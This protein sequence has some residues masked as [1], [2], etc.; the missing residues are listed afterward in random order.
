MRRPVV[1]ANWKMNK[2]I[3]EAIEFANGL[4]RAFY[5]QDTIDIVICPSFVTLSEVKDIILDSNIFLGAQD[6]HFEDKGA[7][8]GEVSGLQLKD[9]GC[10]FVIIGH[11]E[12]RQYFSETDEMINRKIKTALKVGLNPILCIG[13]DLE[14]REKNLTL[15]ILERQIE[16]CLR[17]IR[18]DDILN[19]VIAY[20]P[21]WAI[22]TG[23]NATPQQA[24]EAQQFIRHLLAKIYD[25]DVAQTIRI[26]YGGSVTPE[27]ISEL[28]IQPDIDGAL[29]GGASLNL[30]SFIQI[31]KRCMVS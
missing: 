9:I 12:R 18:G 26:Q 15:D 29:V 27:N 23:K 3:S 31:V 14:E 6:L 16:R 5:G 17:D 4:K 24:E 28:I 22:G 10:R 7:F 20:E 25:K 2:M 11:S 8:T 30:D 19:L 21:V 1:C 13:E